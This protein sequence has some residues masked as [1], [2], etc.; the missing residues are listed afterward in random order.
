[1]KL[2]FWQWI[3]ILILVAGAI[4]YAFFRDTSPRIDENRLPPA[5]TQPVEGDADSI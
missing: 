1:M 4:G 5:T 2:N 3:G